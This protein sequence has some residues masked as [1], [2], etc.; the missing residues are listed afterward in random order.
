MVTQQDRSEGQYIF[1]VSNLAVTHEIVN[2]FK[3]PCAPIVTDEMEE[4]HPVTRLEDMK[5]HPILGYIRADDNTGEASRIA[6][7][8]AANV[9][10]LQH[11]T[12]FDPNATYM[13]TGGLGGLG[14]AISVWF[15]EQGARKLLFLSPHAGLKPHHCQLF[16]ELESLG[17]ASIAVQGAAQNE[18]DV[19]VA[20]QAAKAPIR[21][22]LHLAMQL[23]DA[24][25]PDMTYDDWRAVT[26]PKVAGTRNL[27]SNLGENLDFFV[28]FSSMSTVLYQPGQSNYNAANTFME[29]FCQYRHS[30]GM[31]ASV[32]NVC[33]IEGIGYVAENSAARRKLKSQGHWFLDECGLLEFLE[34]AILACNPQRFDNNSTGS[35]RTWNNPAHIVMG[36]RSE[37]PLEDPSNRSTWKR[38]RRM[39]SYHNI[40]DQRAIPATSGENELQKFLSR[41]ETQP[42]S[43][44]DVSSKRFLAEEIGKKMS[45]FMM[46]PEDDMDISLTLVQVGLDSLMAIEVRRWWNQVLGF[47]ISILEIMNTGTIAELGE[48]AAAGLKQRFANSY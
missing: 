3:D 28:M 9:P 37:T 2:S 16:A 1:R 20:I 7:P 32:L 47:E 25:I 12:R 5:G 8:D 35:G 6:P 23:R 31:P 22:V 33:P 15:A 46:R 36:L 4:S 44:N 10:L 14:R 45:N 41:A 30:L 29:S 34:L 26:S 13:I 40:V 43:L 48:L 19:L 27:H 24:P 42:D 11:G 18:A 38:D 39:G 21:G 17:C